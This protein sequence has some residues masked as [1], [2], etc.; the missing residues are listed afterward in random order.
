MDFSSHLLAIPRVL[1]LVLLY[2]YNLWRLRDQSH[3]SKGKLAPEVPGTLPIIGHLHLLGAEKTLARSLGLLADKYG[4]IFTIWLGVHR[5][6]VVSNH[7]AIKECFTTNDKVL[8]SR[9]RSSHGQCL[10]YNYAAFGF[11]SYGPFW[12]NMWKRYFNSANAGNEQGKRIGELMKEYM[13]ISVVFVPSD[14]IPSLWWM[15]FL[16]PVKT[17]KRLSKEYDSL[18]ESWINEHKLKRLKMGDS[19]SMEEDFI[20]VML[21]VLEDEFFGHSRENIFNN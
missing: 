1:A 19:E 4:P 3:K 20:D 21:S 5:A 9:P 2:R 13:Y 11:S 14:L 8:A 10:S 12:S 7:D 17:M 18:M 6:V 15:N 16:G